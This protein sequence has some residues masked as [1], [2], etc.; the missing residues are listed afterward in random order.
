MDQQVILNP[1]KTLTL[2][3][4]QGSTWSIPITMTD[5]LGS[6]ID[7]TGKTLRASI[8]TA[9]GGTLIAEWTISTPVNGAFTMTVPAD[10]TA[11]ITACKEFITLNNYKT[12]TSKTGKYVT[13]FESVDIDLVVEPLLEAVIY[14]SPEVTT[15]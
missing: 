3:L 10:I 15:A 14:V 7:F 8:K 12:Y 9:Y 13:D 1:D 11:T 2:L 5:S 6:P 4:K